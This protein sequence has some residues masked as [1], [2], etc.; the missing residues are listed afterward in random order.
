[1]EE[2]SKKMPLGTLKLAWV[3]NPSENPIAEDPSIVDKSIF[4]I[5]AR[6]Y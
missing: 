5:K 4:I 3:P 1:M 6:G 2:E